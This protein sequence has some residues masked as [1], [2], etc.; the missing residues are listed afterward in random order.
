MSKLEGDRS[1]S[2]LA[3]LPPTRDRI[4]YAA[5]DLFATWGFHAT[6][7]RQIADAVGIRQPSLFHHFDSKNAIAEALLEWD[8][9]RA[10]PHVTALA[11]LD[12][13]AAVRLYRY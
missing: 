4:L 8:L 1:G 13:P 6:T 12:Q 10:Y 5:G 7:T 2:A 3:A 11:E 9:G